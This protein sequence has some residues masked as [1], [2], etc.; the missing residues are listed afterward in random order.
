MKRATAVVLS[1]IAIGI[2]LSACSGS[3][4]IPEACGDAFDAAAREATTSDTAILVTLDECEN[5]DTWIT[6]LQANPGAGALTSYT[7]E[8][9]VYLLDL[10]CIRR[11]DAVVCVDAA[12]EGLLTFELDDPR[13][14]DL[15]VPRS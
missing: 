8:D 2:S 11:I 3:P 14:A 1:L 15:Q 13:L 4:A 7:R 5:A 10:G 9:A 12:A 6:A